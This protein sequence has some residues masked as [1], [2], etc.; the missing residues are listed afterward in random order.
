MTVQLGDMIS[1][2]F[3]ARAVP[4]R[5]SR[6]RFVPALVLAAL[7]VVPAP[8]QAFFCFGFSVGGG[9]RMSFGG[10]RHYGPP[11]A[12]APYRHGYQWPGWRPLP[13]PATPPPYPM[14]WPYPRR[15]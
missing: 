10:P 4:S 12:Y 1:D 13:W 9:P 2:C 6:W 3:Q 11:A 15:W 7:L 14:P 5:R 8:A